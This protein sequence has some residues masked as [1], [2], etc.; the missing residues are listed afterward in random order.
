MSKELL[1]KRREKI[2]FAKVVRKINLKGEVCPYTFVKT[3]LA[4]EEMEVGQ[5]LQVIVDHLPAVEN[6]PS[7]LMNEGY[8]I[9]EVSQINDTDWSIT[10]RNV[11]WQ[12]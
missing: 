7:S 3:M 5:V 11:P 2:D 9:L 6:V 4:L 8:E 1:S 12:K 10:V